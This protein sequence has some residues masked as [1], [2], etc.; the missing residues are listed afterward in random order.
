M[1]VDIDLTAFLSMTANVPVEQNNIS[2]M[3]TSTPQV[4]FA[5]RPSQ[6]ELFLDGTP[7]MYDTNFDVEIYGEDIDAVESLADTLKPVLNGF[8]GNMGAT[9]VLGMFVSD[10]AEEYTSK[11]EMSSS[12]GLHVAT[13]ALNILHV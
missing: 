2:E 3:K 1:Q 4:Y 9:T 6:Q 12:E 11:A 7:I 10:H 5:R 13:F 8:R